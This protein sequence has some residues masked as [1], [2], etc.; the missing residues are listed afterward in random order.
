MQLSPSQ[1]E[2][3]KKVIFEGLFVYENVLKDI[4]QMNQNRSKRLDLQDAEKS[5]ILTACIKYC[6]SQKGKKA[7]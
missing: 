1:E 2:F 4:E 3:I 5:A 7:K 6:L